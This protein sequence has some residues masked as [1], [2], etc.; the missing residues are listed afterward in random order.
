MCQESSKAMIRRLSG[1][2][3]PFWEN[4]FT[5]KG[6]DIGAGDDLISMDGVIGFDVEDGDANRLHEYFQEGS[7]DYIQASQCLEHMHEPVS[8]LKSWLKVLKI[9]GY[10]VITIPSWELYEGMIWPSRYNPDH[11]ST[12]S[13]WQKGSPAP[14]HAKLPDWLYEN[15]SDHKIEICRLVDTNYNYKIGTSIDQTFNKE[16]AVEAFIEFVVK[17]IK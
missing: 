5:G 3:K 4:V 11:K 13:M 9:G 10:A 16:D 2:E 6:I 7:F 12:F 1:K 8:A 17:K 15:F 14:N